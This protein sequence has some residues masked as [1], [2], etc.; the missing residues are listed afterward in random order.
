MPFASIVLPFPLST[1][2]YLFISIS[3][4]VLFAKASHPHARKEN[5]R[6]KWLGVR[7]TSSLCNFTL[8]TRFLPATAPLDCKPYTTVLDVYEAVSLGSVGNPVVVGRRHYDLI[9]LDFSTT[10]ERRATIIMT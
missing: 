10:T 6:P 5:H 9:G 4:G 2:L 7:E 8:G 1:L 3:D